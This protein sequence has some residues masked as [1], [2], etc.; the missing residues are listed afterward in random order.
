M[1]MDTILAIDSSQPTPLPELE[2]AV[3]GAA[4]RAM[5]RGERPVANAIQLAAGVKSAG[6]LRNGAVTLSAADL[7][8][9]IMNLKNDPGALAEWA[10][11]I[12][13]AGDRFAFSDSEPE[14][15]EH[16]LT[17]IWEIAFGASLGN[18]ALALASAVRSRCR[19]A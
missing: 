13:A 3:E 1:Y 14:Y 4:L 11:F 9:G 2:A 17:C 5:V 6:D 7:A 16:F 10:S 15:W 8:E 19:A 18:S 12:L